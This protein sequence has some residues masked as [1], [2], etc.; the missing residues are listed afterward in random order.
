MSCG[1]IHDCTEIKGLSSDYVDG[2]LDSTQSGGISKHLQ[3]CPPCLAFIDT[4]KATVSLLRMPQNRKAPSTL[5]AKIH[6]RL[7]GTS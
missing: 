6:K 5:R 1:E 3:N 2:D 7:Q 4:L